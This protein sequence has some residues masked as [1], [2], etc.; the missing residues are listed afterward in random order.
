MGLFLSKEGEV[1]LF[2]IISFKSV[3]DALNC[4]FKGRKVVFNNLENDIFID[5]RI[6]MRNEIYA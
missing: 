4:N 1:F 2:S 3:E 6:L 5:M